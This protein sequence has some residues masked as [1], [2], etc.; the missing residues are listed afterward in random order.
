MRHEI[1]LLGTPRPPRIPL[2][3][4]VLVVVACA[5]AAATYAGATRIGGHARTGD[6]TATP[7]K[8]KVTPAPSADEF[9]DLFT[10][11]ANHYATVNGDPVRLVNADCVQAS[12]GHYMC[13][14][15]AER[16]GRA[17]RCHVMQARWTPNG[18]SSF[19]VTLA[20]RS[21]RCGS[22]RE[23]LRSLR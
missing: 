7:A 19:K 5:A 22:L 13:S 6:V 12:P 15:A 21:L 17:R 20:G 4:C 18:A 2:A 8:G 9:A 23:A 14:Y 11:T 1:P 10:G 16:P 3:A